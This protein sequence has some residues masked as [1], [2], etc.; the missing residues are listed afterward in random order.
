MND[1]HHGDTAQPLV[2]HLLEL[3]NRLLRAVVAVLVVFLCLF[4]FSRELYTLVAAPLMQAMPEGTHMIATGV[5]APFLA[6]FKLT[7]YLSIF[8]AVPVILHQAWAFVAPGLYRHEKRLAIPLLMSSVLLFYAGAAFAYFVV[9]PLMFQFFTSVAP[10]GVAVSTDI[11]SYLDFVLA[12]F[13]AFGVAF[14]LPIAIVLLIA[15]GAT[16]AA[17]LA[18]SRAYVVVACFV[19]GMLLTPPDIISQ[20]L[21]ALPM[22]LLFEVGLI[23]GRFVEKEKV[24]RE[25]EDNGVSAKD[26]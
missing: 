4:Y 7:L 15:S 22:W 1:E 14:E 11:S 17:K 2:A 20:T 3:R 12:L 13:L 6:P 8:V 24:Q 19:L 16:T 10:E 5:A 23:F 9:F 21:L 18:S 26:E 25:E